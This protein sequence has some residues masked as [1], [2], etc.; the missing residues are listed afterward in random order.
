MRVDELKRA[1]RAAGVHFSSRLNKAQLEALYNEQVAGGVAAGAHEPGTGNAYLYGTSP[2]FC[3]LA[4]APKA[5]AFANQVLDATPPKAGDSSLAIPTK[6]G[7]MA[8]YRKPPRGRFDAPWEKKY[9]GFPYSG[10]LSL[11]ALAGGSNPGGFS[12]E[13]FSGHPRFPYHDTDGTEFTLVAALT[14]DKISAMQM[15]ITKQEELSCTLASLWRLL[16]I[17]DAVPAIPAHYTTM[18]SAELD[19]AMREHNIREWRLDDEAALE[20]TPIGKLT[21][22]PTKMRQIQAAGGLPTDDATAMT[23]C[24]TEAEDDNGE[25][26]RV[27]RQF[28]EVQAWDSTSGLNWYELTLSEARRTVI[29]NFR[30]AI[31]VMQGEH[32]RRHYSGWYNTHKN[33]LYDTFNI[34]PVWPSYDEKKVNQELLKDLE[35]G[36]KSMYEADFPGAALPPSLSNGNKVVNTVWLI[37]NYID[38]GQA[39]AVSVMGH[40]MVVVGYNHRNFV[41]TATWDRNVTVKPRAGGN[42]IQALRDGMYIYKQFHAINKYWL[43]DS[44][45]EMVTLRQCA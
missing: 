9:K 5:R 23:W 1:L 15:H 18:T 29:T 34:V 10:G 22:L 24:V 45:R 41:L 42:A 12:I 38:N 43:G 33:W 44:I 6:T 16:Q 25:V 21:P 7:E 40:A 14:P 32:N 35:G 2:Y 3:D 13:T 39:V 20:S 17:H 31:R 28:W 30:G 27:Y 37:Q 26:V 8:K 19:A 36:A 4:I 11:T